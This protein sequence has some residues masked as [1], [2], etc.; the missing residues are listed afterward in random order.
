MA[1]AAGRS[2]LQ[3]PA[4]RLRIE[5]SSDVSDIETLD[6]D[7]LPRFN[8]GKRKSVF[9]PAMRIEELVE[10]EP[11]VHDKTL[12]Q[13]ARLSVRLRT[14][15][16]FAKLQPIE[17]DRVVDTLIPRETGAGELVIQQGDEGDFFYV[18]ESGLF[19]V[20]V[21]GVHVAEYNGSGMF[22]ELALLHDC[23]RAATVMSSGHGRLWCLDRQQFCT[24]VLKGAV[25]QRSQIEAS[26]ESFPL[27][28]D[29]S[30]AERT[31]LADALE[32]V[33]FEDGERIIRQDDP[34]DYFYLLLSGQARVS[35]HTTM[36]VDLEIG[37]L[38]PGAY[39]GELALLT[40]NPRAASVW[41]VGRT[42]CARLKIKAF[43]RLLGKCEEIMRRHAGGYEAR[44]QQLFGPAESGTHIRGL[45]FSTL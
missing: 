18:V 15:F 24:T 27:L 21:D 9:A 45:E 34:P 14:C 13:K 33:T 12:E 4:K 25:H 44:L 30:E 6:E 3:S 16:L 10:A 5:S 23:P 26:L 2:P 42:T 29:L 38:L 11:V 37:T 17:L 22:G 1:T 20:F 41:A 40:R 8:T 31:K 32:S 19:D 36:N 39:F 43:E 7:F 35:R 28:A